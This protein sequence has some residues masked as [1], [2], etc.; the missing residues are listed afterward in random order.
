MKTSP[1]GIKFIKHEE[2]VVLRAYRDQVGVLTIGVGHTG[3]DVWEG[4]VISES[5][6]EYLLS[7]DL[8]WCE[9]MVNAYGEHY[10]WTQNEFDALVSYTFNTGNIGKLLN[11]GNYTRHQIIDEFGKHITAKGKVLD[12]LIGRR[13]RE[14]AL[15]AKE[16]SIMKESEITICGHGSGKPSTKVLE[17]YLENRYQQRASNGVKKG[18]VSVRRLSVMDE[19]GRKKFHDNYRWIIG[20][21]IYSQPLRAYVYE[22]YS[23]GNFYSDCSSSGMAAMQKAGYPVSLLN[24]AGIYSSSLFQD[25]PV[26]IVNGHILNPDV[27]K[28]GDCLLFAGNDPSRPKQI[29]HVEY[30]YSIPES[31]PKWVKSDGKWY[32]RLKD[33]QNAH[34]WNIINNHWYYFG[35]DGAAYTGLHT[36][37]SDIHGD[38]TYYFMESGDLEC[39]LCH[40]DDRGALSPW[41]V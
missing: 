12:V 3:N 11:Y 40:T 29:G 23:D 22:P 19:N 14:A 27:L 1:N 20:R 36:I 25:V 39:A 18:L 28:V 8:E 24:T 34:G 31:F 9:K 37:H 38:E 15:F 13:R 5:E 4:K 35:L 26:K 7:K 30:V 2:G 41:I 17:T 16:G 10:K 6:A 33:G 21:N 32:Y